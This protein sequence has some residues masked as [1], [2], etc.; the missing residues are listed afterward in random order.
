MNSEV[1]AG[2]VSEQVPAVRA[3]GAGSGPRETR[4]RAAHEHAPRALQLFPLLPQLPHQ[5]G[6]PGSLEGAYVRTCKMVL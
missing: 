2:A 1:K 5:T 4:L 3:V 6:L